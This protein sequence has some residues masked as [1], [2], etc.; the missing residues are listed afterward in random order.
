MDQFDIESLRLFVGDF[1]EVHVVSFGTDNVETDF[2]VRPAD[3]LNFARHDLKDQSEHHLIN[4][5]SNIKRSIEC[6]ID[7]LLVGFGLFGKSKDERW[8]FPTK[9]DHLN[10][11]GVISPPLLNKIN[12]IRNLVEHEYQRP[13]D[14][15]VEDAFDVATLF[16][17]SSGRFL[18]SVCHELIV[19]HISDKDSFVIQLDYKKEMIM[20]GEAFQ[21]ALI[22]NDMFPDRPIGV[23][24]QITSDSV[25]YEEYLKFF[26]SL[27]PRR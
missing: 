5:I 19:T 17:E 20:L 9:A 15:K 1:R 26:L 27:L 23:T 8:S 22:N 11:V 3:F 4:T 7:S 18:N 10:N 24:K 12:R 2:Q 6:Q 14:E 25:E 21:Y 16:L 13:N